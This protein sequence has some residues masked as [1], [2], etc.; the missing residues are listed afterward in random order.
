M[1]DIIYDVK[2]DIRLNL[3]LCEP[4]RRVL[5]VYRRCRVRLTVTWGRGGSNA[6]TADMRQLPCKPLRVPVNQSVSL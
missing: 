6:W 5:T 4:A 3:K 2:Y 1:Y